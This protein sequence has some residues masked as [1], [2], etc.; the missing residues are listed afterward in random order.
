MSEFVIGFKQRHHDLRFDL[1]SDLLFSGQ[2]F[3]IGVCG[4]FGG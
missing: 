3:P 2:L 1:T 4:K